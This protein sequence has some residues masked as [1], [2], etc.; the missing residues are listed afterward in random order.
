MLIGAFNYSATAAGATLLPLSLLLGFLSPTS[1]KMTQRF[2]A[3]GMLTAGPAVAAAGFA[4]F[5][6]P[7]VAWPYWT[8][9]FPAMLV[10]GMGMTMAVAPLTTTVMDSVSSS[11]GGVASGINNAVA[12]VASLLAI[13]VLG[14][15]FAARLGG[16]VEAASPDALISAFRWVVLACALCALGAAACARVFL[17]PPKT[18][19]AS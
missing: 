13:A 17:R 1:A 11:Q 4:L 8:G 12:R 14:V 7:G 3:R 18:V 10:L 16:P 15:L 2:G 6:L 5:A 19:K 9:F